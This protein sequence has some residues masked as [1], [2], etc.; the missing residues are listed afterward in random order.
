MLLTHI[1]K[2]VGKKKYFNAHCLVEVGIARYYTILH[3]QY[4]NIAI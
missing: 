3:S 4:N 2:E 1:A